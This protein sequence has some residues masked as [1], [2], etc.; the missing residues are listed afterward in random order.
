[1]VYGRQILDK[2]LNTSIML[3]FDRPFGRVLLALLLAGTL[4]HC[5]A[6]DPFAAFVA[7]HGAA[8][9]LLVSGGQVLDG[10]DPAP[11]P[12]DVLVRGDTIAYVGAVDTTL[13]TVAQRIDATGRYVAPG[14]IDTHAHGDP[15]A[16]PA[17]ANFLAQGVT[18]I[19]LGQDGGSP[20]FAELGPWMDRVDRI[21]PGVN[22]AL[23]A[24]HGTLRRLS[25]VDYDPEPDTAGLRRMQDLLAAALAAGCYGLSTGLEYTPGTFAGDAELLALARTVG[26]HDG[27]IMSHIRNEDD[28]AIEASLREL[29]R[30]A[31]F[32]NVHASHL[33]VVYGKG[34]ERADE[35]LALLDSARQAAPHAV[36]ADLY[37]YTA[38]Y[39]GIGIVFPEWAKPPHDYA[40][41]KRERRTELLAFLRQKIQDRNGPEAT[42]FG[43]APYAGQ[44]LAQVAAAQGRPYADVLL[45]IGPGG[46][47][48]AY[49]VMD[50]A[51]QTR[52]LQDPHVMVCS[53]G[54][55]TMHHP[56]GYGSFAKVIEDYVVR[57]SR[58]PLGE[59]VRK[60]TSL[61]AATVG[62]ARRG[63]LRPGYFADLVV[64]DPAAV[65][66]NA[67][68][69]EPHRLATGMSAVVVNGRVAFG[70]G[71]DT[72]RVG[73]MLRKQ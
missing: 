59:A 55:P 5:A 61:P 45:D 42:L 40:Q 57:D 39:T 46:A 34:A 38:S 3:L 29:L 44:T 23:F 51:L 60:M 71:R 68:F 6:P 26:A 58:L 69:S 67:T 17:F 31:A 16:T 21:G 36:T 64:F 4:T 30:Q 28:G 41:V 33:K 50:E 12:A 62:L 65:R 56:R 49:F 52:L 24:G 7:A 72:T 27:L 15:L 1:L 19:C 43:T 54:S 22:I 32:A 48:G 13:I 35:I 2:L 73:R 37:P 14:F 18:T 63:S 10:T 25:G 66:A 11:R 20:A 53:D 70:A 9:D 8:Y 47:S